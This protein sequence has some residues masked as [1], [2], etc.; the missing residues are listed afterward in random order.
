MTRQL[1]FLWLLLLSACNSRQGPSTDPKQNRFYND[2]AQIFKQWHNIPIDSTRQNLELYLQEFPENADAQM[3]MGTLFYTK[4]EYEQA[5]AFY[6][7]AIELKPAQGVYYSALGRIYTIQGKLDSAENQFNSAFGH[8]DSSAYAF[9]GASLLYIKTAN[10]AKSLSLADSALLRAGSS[11]A[12]Y[13]GL[14]YVWLN[15]NEKEKS[16]FFLN[17]AINLGLKDTFAFKQVLAGERKP[18][19][20]YRLYY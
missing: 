16:R 3:L 1:C 4:A 20:Y 10:K 8:H 13:S 17:Q 12:I 11:P 6:K 14:S 2:Y 18:E 7:K 19:D 5:I 9:L 15:W